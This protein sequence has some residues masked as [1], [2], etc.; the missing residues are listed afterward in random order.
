MNCVNLLVGTAT[1]SDFTPARQTC[2]ITQS[3]G[4]EYFMP[5]QN[6][7]IIWDTL[8][9]NPKLYHRIP[10]IGIKFLRVKPEA[11]AT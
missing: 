1:S 9:S 7:V 8:Y 6:L 5:P 11:N 4:T 2:S 10:E 3:N